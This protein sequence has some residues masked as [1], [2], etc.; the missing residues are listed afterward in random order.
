MALAGKSHLLLSLMIQFKTQEEESLLPQ[1]MLST[2]AHSIC[3]TTHKNIH[4]IK[5]FHFKK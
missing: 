4:A 3:T 5:H 2:H 1:V